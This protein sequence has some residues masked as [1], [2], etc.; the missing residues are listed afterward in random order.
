MQNVKAL[1]I[2]DLK[3]IVDSS[4]GSLTKEVLVAED[5]I[6]LLRLKESYASGQEKF[7]PV[8][9]EDDF[10]NHHNFEKIPTDEGFNCVDGIA[11]TEEKMIVQYRN[12]H[13]EPKIK[14][15]K[16]PLQAK[17]LLH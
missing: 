3:V 7:Y 16:I 5:G 8:Y 13:N 4:M 1:V 2:E 9:V 6:K 14:A 17:I 12:R 15:W 11:L 10:N